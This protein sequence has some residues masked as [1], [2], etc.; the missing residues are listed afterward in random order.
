MC[1]NKPLNFSDGLKPNGIMVV[2]ENLTS[3]GEIE[4]DEEDSSVTRPEDL[5][6]SIFERA[7]MTIIRALQQQKMPQGLYLVKM[8][9]LRRNYQ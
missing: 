6:K 2:K 1:I 7:G 3:S 5:L 4:M 9:A 8:Y